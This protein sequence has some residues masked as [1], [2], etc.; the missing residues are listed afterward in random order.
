MTR[1]TSSL[2]ARG[3]R[4]CHCH[5]HL[6]SPILLAK[7]Q[8]VFCCRR[9]AGSVAVRP[10]RVSPRAGGVRP[11]GRAP[12]VAQ[13]AGGS[14]GGRLS[15]RHGSRR[16]A[17]RLPRRHLRHAENAPRA[18]GAYQSM[19]SPGCTSRNPASILL[20]GLLCQHDLAAPPATLGQAGGLLSKAS[21]VQGFS[22][23]LR[24][25]FNCRSCTRGTSSPCRRWRPAW[26]PSWRGRLPRSCCS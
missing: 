18:G 10:R 15:V 22:R 14:G 9:G 11:A 25:D 13:L 24:C 6:L 19:Q 3:P 12:G 20:A 1:S 2:A 4:N 23:R 26:R 5:F 16:A 8:L 7:E 17:Q 21:A